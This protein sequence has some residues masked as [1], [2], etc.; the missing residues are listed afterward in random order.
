MRTS[1][2]DSRLDGAVRVDVVGGNVF[3]PGIATEHLVGPSWNRRR[4]GIV[5]GH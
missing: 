2:L 5:L 4:G 1:A 3:R